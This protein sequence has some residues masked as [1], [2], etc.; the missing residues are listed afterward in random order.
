MFAFIRKK[1][2]LSPFVAAQKYY[3]LTQKVCAGTQR[4]RGKAKIAREGNTMSFSRKLFAWPPNNNT[5]IFSCH[6]FSAVE[7]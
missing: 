7:S 6:L 5:L 4:L 2:I 3:I 1:A